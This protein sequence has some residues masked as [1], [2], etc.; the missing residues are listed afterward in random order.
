MFEMLGK[1]NKGTSWERKWERMQ[2]KSTDCAVKINCGINAEITW[3]MC[4][5]VW[6]TP[7]K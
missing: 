2:K 6:T 1:N 4:G 5:I 7:K 3:N